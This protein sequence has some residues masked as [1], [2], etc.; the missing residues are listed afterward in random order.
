[1]SNKPDTIRSIAEATP[2]T[3]AI[4]AAGSNLDWWLKAF[5]IVFLILQALYLLWRWRRDVKRE[6]ARLAAEEDG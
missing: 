3:A 4:M 5:G 2:A 6:A 1:M